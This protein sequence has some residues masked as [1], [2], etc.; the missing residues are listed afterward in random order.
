MNWR[1]RRER[2]EQR[3]RLGLTGFSLARTAKTLQDEG[4]WTGDAEADSVL[5]LESFVTA[6]SDIFKAEDANVSI[7]FDSILE[8]IEKLMP[9][10]LLILQ[11][12]I[13]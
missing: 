12:F 13:V 4:K 11:L 3:T 6:N 2:R 10:I 8:W 7:D 1:E 5:L 9:L